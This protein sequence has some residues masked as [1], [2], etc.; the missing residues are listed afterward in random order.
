M[1]DQERLL[2]RGEGMGVPQCRP[3]WKKRFLES[4]WCGQGRQTNGSRGGRDIME[5]LMLSV[6]PPQSLETHVSRRAEGWIHKPPSGFTDLPTE[7]SV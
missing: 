3:Q 1:G 6:L 5:T 7:S 2:G 4:P